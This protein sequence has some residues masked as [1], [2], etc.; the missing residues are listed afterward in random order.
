MNSIKIPSEIVQAIYEHAEHVYPSECCGV[1]L[2]SEKDERNLTRFR[3]CQN[4]QDRYHFS[5]PENFP[6]NSNTAYLID[7][8]ELIAIQKEMRENEEVIRVIYHSHID[9]KADFSQ[10]DRRIAIVEG[11]VVYPDTYYFIASVIK[12]KVKEAK[13]YTWNIKERDFCLC[14]ESY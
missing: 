5:E 10:E 7:P 4:V 3:V 13:L 8:K 11:E 9:A 2:G 1:V 12:G 14:E 6:R